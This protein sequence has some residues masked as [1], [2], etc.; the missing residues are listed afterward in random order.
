MIM[1]MLDLATLNAK[2]LELDKK[3]INLGELVEDRINNC[4]KIYLD[5]KKIDFVM[6]IHPEILILV[7]PNY[8]RQLV[9]NLVLK[10]YRLKPVG[11]VTRMVFNVVHDHFI[12]NIARC[13]AKI[14]SPPKSF[15]PIPSA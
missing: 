1:N 2:K 13:G 6:E 11:S 10:L 3:M 5:D 14:S 12:C 7:D 9:D 4:R 15:T 8:M